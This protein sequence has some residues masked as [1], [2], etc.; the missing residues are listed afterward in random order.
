MYWGPNQDVPANHK[1]VE[2]GLK[3]VPD[4]KIIKSAWFEKGYV[5]YATDNSTTP[6]VKKLSDN[7]P[8][9]GRTIRVISKNKK[10]KVY[11]F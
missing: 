3:L 9:T 8:K 4:S 1:I 7:T 10:E 5:K 2:R 11:S 6:V